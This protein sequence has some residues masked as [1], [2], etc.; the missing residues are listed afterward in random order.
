[1]RDTSKELGNSEVLGC[2]AL[3]EVLPDSDMTDQGI[4]SERKLDGEGVWILQSISGFQYAW[5]L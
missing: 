4:Q 3:P 5:V 1:M 2:S